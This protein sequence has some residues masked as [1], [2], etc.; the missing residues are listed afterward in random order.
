MKA[1]NALHHCA[2]YQE[3]LGWY[4]DD[5]NAYAMSSVSCNT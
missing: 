5:N 1:E 3:Q 4:D 2:N